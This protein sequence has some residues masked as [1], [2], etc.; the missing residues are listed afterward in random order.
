MPSKVAAITITIFLEFIIFGNARDGPRLMTNVMTQA[1]SL[2]NPMR[3]G[4]TSCVVFK[5]PGLVATFSWTNV[6]SSQ[7]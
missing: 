3:M 1:M 5:S 7:I 2:L 4:K 6:I